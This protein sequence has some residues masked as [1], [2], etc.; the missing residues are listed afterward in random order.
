MSNEHSI[1]AAN[2]DIIVV[3]YCNSQATHNVFDTINDVKSEVT[4]KTYAQCSTS[5]TVWI[6][7]QRCVN[8][9]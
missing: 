4:A 9:T 1:K 7:C 2:E 6:Q 5:K 8:A 3:K